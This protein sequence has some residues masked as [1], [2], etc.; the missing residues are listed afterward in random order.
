MKGH[1]IMAHRGILSHGA[2]KFSINSKT[3]S[4]RLMCYYTAK[5]NHL[6]DITNWLKDFFYIFLI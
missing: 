1:S 3:V 2:G 5:I 6:E 4:L